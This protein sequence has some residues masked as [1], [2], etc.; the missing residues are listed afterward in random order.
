MEIELSGIEKRTIINGIAN[1]G[2]KKIYDEP[3]VNQLMR[4][5]N[6]YHVEVWIQS[7]HL[8]FFF[9]DVT[10]NGK[11]SI[12]MFSCM[13][14]NTE[15]LSNIENEI[16]FDA[17]DKGLFFSELLFDGDYDFRLINDPVF[18]EKELNTKEVMLMI[19]KCKTLKQ[20]VALLRLQE[21][22][23]LKH[24]FGLEETY[25]K[26]KEKS[27][28]KLDEYAKCMEALENK[29]LIPIPEELELSAIAESLKKK[30]AIKEKQPYGDDSNLLACT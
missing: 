6:N 1:K 21:E 10:K 12:K 14:S 13:K 27:K 17:Y 18:V 5:A 19:K 11:G 24:F 20:Y 26:I 28:E 15:K 3:W 4:P 2:Y 25:E 8:Y 23:L 7:E 9:S 30:E 22:L 29:L 16:N